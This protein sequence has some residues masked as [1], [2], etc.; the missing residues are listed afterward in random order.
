MKRKSQ[1]GGGPL[2]LRRPYQIERL[3]AKTSLI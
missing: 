3:L 1:E 2:L